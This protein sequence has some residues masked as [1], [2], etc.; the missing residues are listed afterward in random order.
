MTLTVTNTD[1]LSASA[2]L[3]VQ[4]LPPLDAASVSGF[5]DI[6]SANNVDSDLNDPDSEIVSNDTIA[7]A[8]FLATPTQLGGYLNVP[9][10]GASGPLFAAGDAIDY[11]RF[12]AAGGEVIDLNIADKDALDIDL[13]LLTLDG[14]EVDA[15]INVGSREQVRVPEAGAYLISVEIFDGTGGSNYI[16]Q[17]STQ[18]LGASYDP[19]LWRASDDFLAELLY[20]PRETASASAKSQLRK[21][22]K[23]LPTLRAG[24]SGVYR[25]PQRETHAHGPFP[26][27]P[28]FPDP[29][30]NDQPK[31]PCFARQ[32]RSS[33]LAPSP[34]RNPISCAG[35]SPYL[36]IPPTACNGITTP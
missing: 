18:A 2:S 32:R 11:F 22:T 3:T 16:L 27:R 19:T 9:Q 17:L 6:A 7:E 8:Q 29:S 1:D 12:D 10:G 24:L 23:D 5:V 4:I 30:V 34:T 35:P 20:K 33:E 36:M 28:L 13:Y 14:V 26:T 31:A 15:S 25:L 21:M